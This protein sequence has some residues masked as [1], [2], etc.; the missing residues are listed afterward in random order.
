MDL[1][2]PRLSLI[3]IVALVILFAYGS[4]LFLTPIFNP[5]RPGMTITKINE[6]IIP[7]GP[8]VHM[9]DEDF[10]EYPSLAPA[11]R[12]NSQQG[13]SRE[14]G[15]RINYYIGLSWP[16]YNRI[17]G[18]KFFKNPDILIEYKGDYYLFTLPWIP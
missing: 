14:N 13:Y 9:V 2:I 10:N 17:I 7:D 15:T 16:E 3:I 6:S 12:D 8:I 1:K 18:S 4:Y 5:D 11:I